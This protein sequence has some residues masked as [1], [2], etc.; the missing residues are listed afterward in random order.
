MIPGNSD[1]IGVNS[2]DAPGTDGDS[3]APLIDIAIP[4]QAEVLQHMEIEKE[5]AL[6]GFYYNAAAGMVTNCVKLIPLG[7]QEG[8]ELLFS[9]QPLIKDL[10]KDAMVP[11]KTFIGKACPGFDIR[12]MQHEQLYSRL[13]MS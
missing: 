1:T 10:V 3:P 5:D 4:S 11:D 7:Q 9:L 6:T 2:S 13:Y 8:Q 12:S